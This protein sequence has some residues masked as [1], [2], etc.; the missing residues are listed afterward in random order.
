MKNRGFVLLPVLV[1][2]AV[3]IAIGGYLAFRGELPGPPKSETRSIEN[4]R[5]QGTSDEVSAIEGDLEATSYTEIDSDLTE[6][7][8]ELDAALS[9]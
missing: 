7:E 6:I 9:E 2:A 1:V 4:I 5:T 3:L 8:A